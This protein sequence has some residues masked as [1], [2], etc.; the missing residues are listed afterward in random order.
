MNKNRNLNFQSQ[1][2]IFY[3]IECLVMTDFRVDKVNYTVHKK[4]VGIRD[5]EHTHCELRDKIGA[6]VNPKRRR[7]F[8]SCCCQK[9]K[10]NHKSCHTKQSS[11]H[12]V[13]K[14]ITNIQLVVMCATFNMN[15]YV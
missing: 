4:G 6:D 13:V 2:C 15:N 3:E 10:N 5:D 1:H 7:A 9:G 14:H 12:H 11:S 8:N